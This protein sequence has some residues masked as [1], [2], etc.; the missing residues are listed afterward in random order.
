MARPRQ[1]EPGNPR[2]AEAEER[3]VGPAP[4]TV[5]QSGM[6]VVTRNGNM[7]SGTGYSR[8]SG[9]PKGP[10]GGNAFFFNL[11]VFPLL[12]VFRRTRLGS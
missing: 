12:L 2:P 6:L 11:A 5:A 7:G 4:L 8:V 10:T 9:Y 3:R 1:F